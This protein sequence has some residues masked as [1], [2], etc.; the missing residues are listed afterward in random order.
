MRQTQTY[1]RNIAHRI[2]CEGGRRPPRQRIS[3]A[4]PQ[5]QT[6]EREGGRGVPVERAHLS[7]APCGGTKGTRSGV[8]SCQA[9]HA[10]QLSA[11]ASTCE[12]NA[13]HS[14]RASPA[15]VS[16]MAPLASRTRKVGT[17][18][19]SWYWNA[20][21]VALLLSSEKNRTSRR[22][23]ASR[24]VRGSRALHAAHCLLPKRTTEIPPSQA[25]AV[26]AARSSAG[27]GICWTCIAR[28]DER[29]GGRSGGGVLKAAEPPRSSNSVMVGV[30]QLRRPATAGRVADG[31]QVLE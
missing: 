23:A 31:M 17:A 24:R 14:A 4:R 20:S 18:V 7:A 3:P 8:S 29:S 5:Q 25:E 6:G 28:S 11:S 1:W 26:T 13:G 15:L 21:A 22:A 12:R 9:A 10:S 2:S 30:P 19:I 27:D 16:R